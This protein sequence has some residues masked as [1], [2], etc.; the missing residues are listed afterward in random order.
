MKLNTKRNLNIW[1]LFHVCILFVVIVS[2]LTKN[3]KITEIPSK[4]Q[5][6]TF[7]DENVNNED[8]DIIVGSLKV[9]SVDGYDSVKFE[10]NTTRLLIEEEDC[11][12]STGVRKEVENKI[13]F[14]KIDTSEYNYQQNACYIHSLYLIQVF[15]GD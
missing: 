1:T 11:I 12:K 10:T 9:R 3:E 8:T 5:S 7:Y 15:N 14:Y 13:L 6:T 2:I 4:I